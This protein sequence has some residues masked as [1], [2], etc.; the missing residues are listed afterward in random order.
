[1]GRT[2]LGSSP[3]YYEIRADN[4]DEERRLLLRLLLLASLSPPLVSGPPRI[5]PWEEECSRELRLLRWDS[6]LNSLLAPP[7]PP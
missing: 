1:V 4:S 6:L 3:L 7:P 5:N 2:L